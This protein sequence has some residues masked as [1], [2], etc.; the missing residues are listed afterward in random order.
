MN[1]HDDDLTRFEA[2]GAPELPA[3]DVEGHVE[4]DGARIGYAT[5]GAGA[6]VVLLHGGLGHSGNWGHQ[7]PALVA[8]G[9]R[10][11][12]V[13]SRGHGRSTRDAEPFHY[14]RMAADVIAV[15][16]ALA[17]ARASFVGWSDGA[18]LALIVGM[19]APA[20]VERV[21]FFGCNVDPSGA[22]D[23]VPSAVLGRCVRRHA[24]DY[25][26]LSSTPGDFKAFAGAV[27]AMMKSEPNYSAR[28]LAA[29]T[30]PVTIAQ[31]EGDEFVR[32]EH[33]EYLA[34]TIPNAR[35][36]ILP[37]VTHFAPLQR[38]EVFDA[39]VLA[40]LAGRAEA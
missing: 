18:L 36:V 29:I 30:V 15:L 9:H 22:K 3:A 19:R 24:A 31:S 17:I 21:F 28:E 8:S 11:V 14:E 35:L 39:A 34:R 10:V 5:Y 26:R 23:V 16:D 7:V 38:P 6:P 37:G 25:A 32:P 13:D 1:A 27:D 20:R 40:F 2:D 33:A 4:H 12:L